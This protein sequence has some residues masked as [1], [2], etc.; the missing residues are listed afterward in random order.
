MFGLEAVFTTFI[1]QPFLNVLIFLYWMLGFFL[2]QP[3]MGVAVILLTVFIR[4]LMIPLTIS[5]ERSEKDRR[6]IASAVRA[7]EEDYSHDPVK[8]K[9]ARKRVLRENSGIVWGE[10]AS[11]VVQVVIALMLWRMFETG[12]PG[13][14]VNL[15]YP[16]MPQ[17]ETPFNLTFLGRFDLSQSSWGLNFL[18]SFMIFLVETVSILTSPYPP[19]KGEVVRLQLT[20]PLIAFIIFMGLPAGK[21]LFVITTLFI[22]LLFRIAFFVRRRFL[23]YKSRWEQREAATGDSA[24]QEEQVLV[25][26]NA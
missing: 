22:S 19:E 21:K 14:D 6:R 25:D 17:V 12:L 26:A 11:L 9:A 18:Q 15:I 20:L 1:Y 10:V 13:D 5:S 16:F 24:V 2:K 4:I 8:R 3:D 7:V 23:Q